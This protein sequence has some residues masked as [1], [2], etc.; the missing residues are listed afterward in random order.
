M[1]VSDNQHKIVESV[2]DLSRN[3]D[4]VFTCGGIGP[5]HDDITYEAIAAAFEI[6][7]KRSEAI[8]E[9]MM[10]TWKIKHPRENAD[11]FW[12]FHEP[13]SQLRDK[14]HMAEVPTD[15]TNSKETQVVFVVNGEKD[16]DYWVPVVVVGNVFILPGVP[17]GFR[18]LLNGLK[19]MMQERLK[20]CGFHRFYL[21]IPP[22][23][24][25]GRYRDRLS[26][27]SEKL[28]G[29]GIDVGSH[30]RGSNQKNIITLTGRDLEVMNGAVSE[31]RNSIDGAQQVN[32]VGEDDPKPGVW[33]RLRMYLTSLVA[34]LLGIEINIV[35]YK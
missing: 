4:V 32:Y 6:P 12:N 33:P 26:G 25:E 35:K 1:V 2:R 29:H 5:T 9:R 7:L 8:I 31:I 17:K 22:K 27:L 14:L 34:Q 11:E 15:P 24:T 23:L 20:E 10:T 19:P 13:D 18:K 28:S 3:Y 21:S 30:A 16:R